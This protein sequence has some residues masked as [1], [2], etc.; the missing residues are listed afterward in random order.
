MIIRCAE[1]LKPKE[2]WNEF[3]DWLINQDGLRKIKQWAK[4]YVKE[5]GAVEKSERAPETAARI[6]M[7][8]E[9][10]GESARYLHKGV[11][12]DCQGPPGP[13]ARLIST[14]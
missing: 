1:E 8:E 9:S 13:T 2:F 7:I 14:S 12:V 6:E 5:H 10:F 4:D 3:F 11:R